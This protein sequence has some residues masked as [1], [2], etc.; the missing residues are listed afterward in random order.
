LNYFAACVRQH[1]WNGCGVDAW[2]VIFRVLKDTTKTLMPSC[3]FSGESAKLDAEQRQQQAEE[4]VD[5][6]PESPYSNIIANSRT[7]KGR[8]TSPTQLAIR[9]SHSSQII[10]EPDN[11]M[12]RSLEAQNDESN[13]NQEI[14][15]TGQLND[16]QQ[17]ISF[18]IHEE[19]TDN[20]L[21]NNQ[22]ISG[23]F[24]TWSSG[25]SGKR[26]QITFVLIF[27][28]ICHLFNRIFN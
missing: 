1:I 16:N 19:S 13:L 5:E 2:H 3:L 28:C 15:N 4:S 23:H 22:P 11:V 6:E 26:S 8:S 17:P 21:T 18:E 10:D 27:L 24:G 20:R 7:S 25:T 14:S 12:S 9:T